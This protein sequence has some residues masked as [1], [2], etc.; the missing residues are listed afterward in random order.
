MTSGPSAGASGRDDD[1]S[2]QCLAGA[3]ETLGLVGQQG[4]QRLPGPYEIPG[5]GQAEHAGGGGD[6]VLLA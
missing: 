1:R 3:F 4:Q 2:G 6:R 5:L